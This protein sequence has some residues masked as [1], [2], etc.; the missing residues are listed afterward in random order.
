MKY[1]NYILLSVL[2]ASVLGSCERE[3][4]II[5]SEANKVTEPTYSDIEGFY[6]L[7]EG[8]MGENK[9]SLDY[10]DA[11][12]GV[13][14]RNIY[15]ERNPNVIK[16]LGDVGNDLLI[17]NDKLF[18][19]INCSHKVE[20]MDAATAARIDKIDV[21]NCRYIIGNGD[22]VYVSSYVGPVQ[23][24]PQAPKGAVF[25]INANTFEI[26]GSVEVGYQPEQ[27][28][29]IGDKLYVA[30][31]GGYRVPNYDNT[32]SVIDLVSFSVCDIIVLDNASNFH[33]LA[34]DRKGRLWLTSRGD[35]YGKHSELYVLDPIGKR[36]VKTF[37]TP[38]SDMWVDDNKLYAI[39]SEYSFVNGETAPA[40]II[41]DMDTMEIIED[42][43]IKDGTDA[44]IKRPY[45]I[46]VN[47]I[48]KDIYICDAK[49]Y[50]VSGTLYCFGT[51]GVLK[52]KQTTGQIPGCIE[53]RGNKT[54]QGK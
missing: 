36:V 45:T 6:L 26:I 29:I 3:D 40:Y 19:V 18:A 43:I 24:D 32:V 41:I 5:E 37:E 47:P 9:S 52:W 21:P 28:T 27:M 4:F 25:K 42:N 33:C 54:N 2:L 51:D 7:N 20:V 50:V 23:V 15:A 22:Y 39:C 53:F 10:F 46:A 49:M 34:N 1:I 8:N 17:Y 44:K 16:D 48:S 35:Y 31:S 12:E 13:Y 30:N 38:I 14:Y 11:T